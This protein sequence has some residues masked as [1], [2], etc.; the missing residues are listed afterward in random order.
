M[1][2]GHIV[3]QGLANQ[4]PL[5]FEKLGFTSG[6]FANPAD[7]FMKVLALNYPKQQEDEDKVNK[8]VYHYKQTQEQEAMN[9]MNSVTVPKLD[10][11]VVKG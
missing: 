7:I 8:L 10:F 2:D 6:K 5:Y 4:S 1:A 9:E 11:S 3:Y